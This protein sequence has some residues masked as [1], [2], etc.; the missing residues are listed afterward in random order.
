MKM[1]QV[2]AGVWFFS[3]RS[4]AASFNFFPCEFYPESAIETEHRFIQNVYF[5][6]NK[7][8]KIIM[9][10]THIFIASMF[11]SMWFEKLISMI[12]LEIKC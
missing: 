12:L 9:H 10:L 8:I 11:K 6:R 4:I 5:S 1:K 7:E 2:S 3:F